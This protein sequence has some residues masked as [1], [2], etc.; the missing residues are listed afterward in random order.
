MFQPTS[1]HLLPKRGRAR[2]F[3]HSKL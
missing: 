3:L 1:L 2:R